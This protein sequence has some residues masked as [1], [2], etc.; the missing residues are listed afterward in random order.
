MNTRDVIGR[1]IVKVDHVRWYNAHLNRLETDVERIW[2]DDGSFLH[3][4]AY[5][6]P[7]SPS[8]TIFH[9]KPSQEEKKPDGG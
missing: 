3:P 4:F 7:D 2:L 1:R 8:G 9:I 6:T 5:E